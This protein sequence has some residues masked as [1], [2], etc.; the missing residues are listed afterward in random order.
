MTLLRPVTCTPEMQMCCSIGALNNSWFS[1]YSPLLD[2]SISLAAIYC[3]G[4]K[5]GPSCGEKPSRNLDWK[6]FVW[7]NFPKVSTWMS[8]KCRVVHT[9][10][11]WR[12]AVFGVFVKNSCNSVS[13][14]WWHFAWASMSVCVRDDLALFQI[15][16]PSAPQ[17]R[18]ESITGVRWCW[19]V[20]RRPREPSYH[21]YRSWLHR[22]RS[23]CDLEP[24]VLTGLARWRRRD[25]GIWMTPH[26][27][28]HSSKNNVTLSDTFRQHSHIHLWCFIKTDFPAQPTP[29]KSVQPSVSLCKP[30]FI[31]QEE[32]LR[33]ARVNNKQKLLPLLEQQ[34]LFEHVWRSQHSQSDRSP[35]LWIL[36]Q[37]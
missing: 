34:E 19:A 18:C 35:K 6:T 8:N 17:W 13:S 31:F 22:P 21:T 5:H 27:H 10:P 24:A 7:R 11:R 9:C 33:T 14:S 26:F 28:S 32:L 30:H 23:S 25:Q 2:N 1:F 4:K 12:R 3:G 29:T 16:S 15:Y 20:G 37:N 36:E